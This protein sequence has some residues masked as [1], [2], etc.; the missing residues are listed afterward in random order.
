MTDCVFCNGAL[1]NERIAES[2]RFLA[3]ADGYPVSP[4]HARIVPREHVVS[5]ADLTA[6]ALGEAFGLLAKAR[7]LIDAAY[8]PDAYNVG[9]NDG[10]AAGRTVDHLHIHLIPRYEGDVPDPRG[11]VRLILPGPSPDLWSSATPASAGEPKAQS[12]DLRGVDRG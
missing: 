1:A 3:L 9:I 5:L 2:P 10:R 8:R 12:K 4:G 7:T 11:G 6:D